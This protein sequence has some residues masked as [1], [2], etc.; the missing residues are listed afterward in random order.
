MQNTYQQKLADLEASSSNKKVKWFSSTKGYGFITPDEGEKDVFVHYT[1]L[2]KSGVSSL[3]EG[4]KLSYEIEENNGKFSA[5]NLKLSFSSHLSIFGF[6][7][8]NKT[9]SGYETQNGAGIITSSPLFN[10]AIKVL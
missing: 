2:E 4:Q 3:S 5:V 8:A 1:A 10:V 9:I 6:P 7:P